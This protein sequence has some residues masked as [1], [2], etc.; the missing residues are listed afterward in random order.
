M[1]RLSRANLKARESIFYGGPE[2]YI[3]DIQAIC[4]PSLADCVAVME[5][6]CDEV[7]EMQHLLRNGT[8]DLPRMNKI[9]ANERVGLFLPALFKV[10]FGELI[11]I[12]VFPRKVFLLVDEGTIKRYKSEL[13]DEIEPAIAELI[14]RAEQ[15]L[16]GMLKKEAALQIKVENAKN[17]L[18]TVR[19]ATTIAQKTEARQLQLLTKQRERLEEEVKALE[20]EVEELE[21]KMVNG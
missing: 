3:G 10:T 4:P 11:R 18:R 9:L 7:F 16:A 5:D 6:C 21:L 17:R 13:A 14:E 2:Q 20:K 1:S 8:K 12:R 19:G 15:G